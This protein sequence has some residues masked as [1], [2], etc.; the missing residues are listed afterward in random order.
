M[1]NH[2]A[3][4]VVSGPSGSGKHTVLASLMERV[5]G[6]E[7]SISTTTRAPREGEVPG[8]DYFFLQRDEFLARANEGDF[9]EWAEVHGNLYGTQRRELDRHL[10]S[11]N[12]VLL[13]VDV[14]GMRSLKQTDLEPV[15]IFLMPP[16]LEELEA[17]LRKRATESEDIVAR[18]LENARTEMAAQY[19]YD[20]IIV[21]DTVDAAVDR[22]QSIIEQHR[23]N[24]KTQT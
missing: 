12:D 8:Q 4:F 9:V 20:Y 3:V 19:E 17:R 13:Q 10:T 7:L 22:F 2:G 21:N 1:R 23:H 11:G 14:Q 18:R 5:P 15:T 6:L 16:S 24:R